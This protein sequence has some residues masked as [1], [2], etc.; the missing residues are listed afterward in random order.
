[1]W[2]I[3]DPKGIEPEKHILTIKHTFRRGE[4]ARN[5]A[6]WWRNGESSKTYQ[7][8]PL[9]CSPFSTP[10]GGGDCNLLPECVFFPAAVPPRKI[11]MVFPKGK[12][13]VPPLYPP[14]YRTPLFFLGPEEK[15]QCGGGG[16]WFIL[17]N[18]SLR[19]PRFIGHYPPP[20]YQTACCPFD[21]WG[22]FPK[23]RPEKFE[24]KFPLTRHRK[25]AWE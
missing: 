6:V 25:R 23:K 15:V 17:F 21:T 1:M 20:L 7:V 24:K 4:E 16:A 5:H 13:V 12:I 2:A 9:H 8:P 18:F 3:P 14:L 11:F 19:P 10:L 22:N